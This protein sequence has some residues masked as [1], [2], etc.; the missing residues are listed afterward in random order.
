MRSVREA[1]EHFG[2]LIAGGRLTPADRKRA[3]QALEELSSML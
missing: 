3:L 1:M 2:R